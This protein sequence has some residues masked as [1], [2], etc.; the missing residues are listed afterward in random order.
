MS[1]VSGETCIWGAMENEL[2]LCALIAVCV[3]GG[4]RR[5]TLSVLIL[6]SRQRN[7][8]IDFYRR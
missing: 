7:Y 6:I 3:I 5:R 4:R 8:S 2:V 1:S